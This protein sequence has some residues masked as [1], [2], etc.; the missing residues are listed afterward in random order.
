MKLFYSA[1]DV[2]LMPRVSDLFTF[3]VV[4]TFTGPAALIAI[5]LKS[6]NSRFYTWAPELITYIERLTADYAA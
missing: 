4:S 5:I 1:F 6:I 3:Y 2:A